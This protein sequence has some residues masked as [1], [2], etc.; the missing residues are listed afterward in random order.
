MPGSHYIA[1]SGMRARLDQLDRLA[2]D[3]ANSATAGYKGERITHMQEPRPSFQDSLDS[4]IDVSTSGRRLDTAAGAIEATGRDLD[5]AIEGQGFFEVQ[6]PAGPRYTR[7]GHF[8]RTADGTLTTDDGSPVMGENGPIQL[9]SGMVSIGEDGTVRAGDGVVG[10]LKMVA[11]ADPG[12]LTQEGGSRLD[13][14]GQA[15]LPASGVVRTQALER[16]NVSVVSHVAELTTVTRAFEALQKSMSV[17]MN[18]IDGRAIDSF[19]RR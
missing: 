6:T 9:G 10:R 4:A 7:N 16:S 15:P 18:D 11:F 5:V 2:A 12:Q 3:L 8:S 19:G 14:G 17:L 13:A 1:L